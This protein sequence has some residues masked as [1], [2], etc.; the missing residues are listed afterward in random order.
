M[1]T[2]DHCRLSLI[3]WTARICWWSYWSSANRH[4]WGLMCHNDLKRNA[5]FLLWTGKASEAA[6][7]WSERRFA[8][9]ISCHGS[10]AD[11]KCIPVSHFASRTANR[12]C[13]LW[14]WSCGLCWDQWA[15]I[16]KFS[17]LNHRWFSS[18]P[19]WTARW[20]SVSRLVGNRSS[21][22]SYRYCRTCSCSALL[23]A[24]NY[25]LCTEFPSWG[26]EWVFGR[27]CQR[28]ILP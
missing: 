9:P 19:A 25:L 2:W 8:C 17:F 22:W 3:C 15:Y 18:V 6:L 24:P 16:S 26:S 1:S 14:A 5:Q 12:W 20:T 28:Y 4:Y 21:G 7:G 11:S 10:D 13:H 27:A 23:V